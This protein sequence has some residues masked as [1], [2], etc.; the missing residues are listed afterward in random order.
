MNNLKT[1]AAL[2]PVRLNSEILVMPDELKESVEEIRLRV[3]QAVTVLV[4][5]SEYILA[6]EKQLSAYD[7]ENV[8]ECASGASVHSVENELSNGFINVG[9]GIRLGVCGTAVMRSGA[10]GGMRE[11]SSLSIRI[12][13]EIHDCAQK[14]LKQMLRDGLTDILIISPPGGGKT[15]CLRE[16]IRR[17]SDMGHRVSV[18]DE[19]GEI[20]AIVNGK[21]QFDMGSH[22]DVICDAP[23]AKAAMMMIRAMNPE[24][25]AMD[26][27]SSRED[28]AAVFEASG[29]GVHILATAHAASVDDLYRRRVYRELMEADVF[30]YCLIIENKEG[31]RS[32]SIE[33]L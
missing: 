22:C 8:L 23:K 26:E 29:C 16:Y 31:V 11:L 19:R 28:I 14:E 5:G 13:K 18:A 7:L 20:C 6:P 15:T 4:H 21:P 3:G 25:L 2:L 33:E 24:L 27:I 9:G 10:V 30:R 17:I 12:P 32:Y 1:A